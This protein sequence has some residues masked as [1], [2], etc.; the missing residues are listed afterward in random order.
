M[1]IA[2][3][4]LIQNFFF[5]FY[6]TFLNNIEEYGKNYSEAFSYGNMFILTVIEL[7]KIHY[8]YKEMKEEEYSDV[9][10][11]SSCITH[12]IC[13][14]VAFKLLINLKDNAS[15]MGCWYIIMLELITSL[16]YVNHNLVAN[17]FYNEIINGIYR[18]FIACFLFSIPI[19]SPDMFF[20]VTL[21]SN[22][23]M[24]I[25]SIIRHFVADTTSK[26]KL[27]SMKFIFIQ[28]IILLLLYGRLLFNKEEIFFYSESYWKN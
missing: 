5:L 17:T 8:Q 9:N 23:I 11:Y 10:I 16:F 25:I 13:L 3:L 12:L 18:L 4:N 26:Q 21:F 15:I 7:C 1:K 27:S 24:S 28:S 2:I 14:I 6:T 19:L 22:K 20:I